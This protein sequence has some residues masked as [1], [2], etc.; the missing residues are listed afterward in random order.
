MPKT[1]VQYVCQSCGA[2]FRQ[3]MGRC[4]TCQEWDSLQE[5]SI[6]PKAFDLKGL[7]KATHS[8]PVRFPDLSHEEVDRHPSGWFELDRVLGGGIVPGSLVLIGGEPGIGKSTLLL[9]VAETYTGKGHSVLYVSAEESLSQLKQRGKR[10]GVSSK[11]L[12]FWAEGDLS[13]LEMIIEELSPGLILVD[14][15]QMVYHP[16]LESS[17]GSLIQVRG[18]S[19]RLME[20]AKKSSIPIFLVGHVTKEGSLAGPKILEHLVDTVLYFEGEKA[21]HYRI[22]RTIKNRFGTVDEVGIFRMG[23]EGLEEVENPSE[24]FLEEKPPGMSGS[25]IVSSLE[26]T[27]PLFL[28]V[29][30]LVCETKNS[31][32]NRRSSGIDLNR[33]SLILAVLEKRAR[34][35]VDRADVFVNVAG[36]MKINEPAIDLGL[37]MAIASAAYGKAIEDGVVWIG[38]IGL[39]GEIRYVQGLERRITEARNLGFKRCMIPYHPKKNISLDGIELCPIR[40]LQE[41][42]ERV[43]P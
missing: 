39:G 14:S 22:L 6:L 4:S 11:E 33:L 41:G 32:P 26:G 2:S 27:R 10:L 3:W 1:T 29:Q 7:S 24:L 34:V 21:L 43:F 18:C 19:I 28:E 13:R 12:F 23:E 35:G 5:E 9:Q 36:G 20:I 38:E 37:A 15:I 30:A 25:V 17:P 31:F 16:E 42:L 40:T 8:I